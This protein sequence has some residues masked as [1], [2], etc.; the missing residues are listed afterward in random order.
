MAGSGGGAA[1]VAA[2]ASPSG[3]AD[4]MVGGKRKGSITE[5]Q[6]NLQVV[7]QVHLEKQPLHYHAP[8]IHALVPWCDSSVRW[9]VTF[10]PLAGCWSLAD[11]RNTLKRHIFNRPGAT[12]DV[13]RPR[14]AGGAA[15]DVKKVRPAGSGS[16]GGGGGGGGGG[17]VTS[18][19][20]EAAQ[21]AVAGNTG[22]A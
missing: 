6:V 21:K 7:T 3:G 16:S 5:G 12:T 18:A 10:R 13:D 17:S 9:S 11:V 15:A 19:A 8:P 20:A 22:S 14:A 1:A 4:P 2:S